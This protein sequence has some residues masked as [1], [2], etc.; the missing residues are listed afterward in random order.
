[1]GAA[2]LD[3]VGELFGLGV[4]A[5]R[6]VLMAGRRR[7]A[8]SEA[9]AMCMAAE[10]CRWRIAT[11]LLVVGMDGFLLPISPPAIFDG[12][13]GDDFVD[14][15]VGLRAAAG[16]PDAK[17]EVAVE[18]SGDDF[19]GGLGDELGLFRRK[20]AEVLIDQRG[21]FLRMPKARMSSGGM[22]SL[23]MAKWMSERAVARR[24]KRSA[25]TRSCPWSRTRC[26][27]GWRLLV[28]LLQ[29]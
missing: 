1:M 25:G 6:R 27:S 11:Y 10:T 29:T 4:E 16:L 19:I 8:V 21:G 24:S 14:V 12:A 2:D 23:P 13:I 22:T 15:H 18:F 17:R 9:A 5:S 20:L 26:G 28:W 3:D 7:R